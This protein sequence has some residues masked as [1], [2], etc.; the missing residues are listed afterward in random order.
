[1]LKH[2]AFALFLALLPSA[3][4]ADTQIPFLI[5][6]STPDGT[7]PVEVQ[8]THTNSQGTFSQIEQEISGTLD[9]KTEIVFT[10]SIAQ[11]D[12]SVDNLNLKGKVDLHANDDTGNYN[13]HAESWLTGSPSSMNVSSNG[14]TDSGT[15]APKGGSSV[16]LTLLSSSASLLD[17]KTATITISNYSNYQTAFSATIGTK[18]KDLLTSGFLISYEVRSIPLPAALPLFGLALAGIAS[19]K[20]AAKK[21]GASRQA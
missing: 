2:V 1:M 11:G 9:K 15:Y 17:S 5:T 12:L 21:K 20:R 16:N 18:I 4:F 10:Y 19:A 7:I 3:A 13:G 8:N 6:A 14:Q